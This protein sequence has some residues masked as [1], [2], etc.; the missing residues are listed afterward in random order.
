MK[1]IKFKSRLAVFI[2]MIMLVQTLV[3]VFGYTDSGDAQEA[4]TGVYEEVLEEALP[5]RS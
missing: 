1:R 2:T 5:N 3:P 4:D